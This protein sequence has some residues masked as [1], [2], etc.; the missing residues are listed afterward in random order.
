LGR[1]EPPAVKMFQEVGIAVRWRL[2][3][4]MPIHE[5]VHPLWAN[6]AALLKKAEEKP[7]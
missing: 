5:G 1:R 2:V 4:E 6:M 3:P 7:N